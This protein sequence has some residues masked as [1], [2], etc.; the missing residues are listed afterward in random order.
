[1]FSQRNPAFFIIYFHFQG[2]IFS[3]GRPK[4]HN[5]RVGKGSRKMP[6][7]VHILAKVNTEQNAASAV[8]EVQGAGWTGSRGPKKTFTPAPPFLSPHAAK[9]K[10][11][12]RQNFK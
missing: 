12:N 3:Q 11:H 1:M 8:L 5:L 2:R 4:A 6:R 7:A 10:H 9:Q